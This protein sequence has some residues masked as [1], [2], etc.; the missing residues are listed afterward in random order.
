MI[1]EKSFKL[2]FSKNQVQMD[3]VKE[4]LQFNKLTLTY[5][6]VSMTLPLSDVFVLIDVSQSYVD[7]DFQHYKSHNE[8]FWDLKLDLDQTS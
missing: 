7:H 1:F 6:L 3:R 5:N 2:D 4:L 8:I